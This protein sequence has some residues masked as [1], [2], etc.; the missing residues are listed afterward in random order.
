[1]KLFAY[2]VDLRIHF[3]LSTLSKLLFQVTDYSTVIMI[4]GTEHYRTVKLVVYK[5]AHGESVSGRRG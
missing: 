2:L 1:M 4:L 3:H 5:L